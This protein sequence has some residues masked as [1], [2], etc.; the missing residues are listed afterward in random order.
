MTLEQPATLYELSAS[1]VQENAH[2]PDGVLRDGDLG[3]IVDWLQD[4]SGL[5][6]CRSVEGGWEWWLTGAVHDEPLGLSVD[7]VNLFASYV[8]GFPTCLSELDLEFFS[9]NNSSVE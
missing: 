4:K 6:Y 3:S 9:N 1:R 8:L 7:S 5:S 2:Y